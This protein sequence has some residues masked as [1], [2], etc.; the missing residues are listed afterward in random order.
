[1]AGRLRDAIA[2]SVNRAERFAELPAELACKGHLHAPARLLAAMERRTSGPGPEAEGAVRTVDVANRRIVVVRP[3][4][5][6]GATAT[7]SDLGRQLVV[8][9]VIG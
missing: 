5:I 2:A 6:T 9:L 4:Q 7:A 8:C 3:E 1:M